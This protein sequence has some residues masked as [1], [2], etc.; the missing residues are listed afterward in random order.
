MANNQQDK[1]L[2]MVAGILVAVGILFLLLAVA[3]GGPGFWSVALGSLVA[4]IPLALVGR[5]KKNGA[6][7]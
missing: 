4:G 5:V 1:A 7:Q 2:T 3:I 6:E